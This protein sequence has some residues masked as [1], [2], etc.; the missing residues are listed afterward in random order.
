MAAVLLGV[1]ATLTAVALFNSSL[2][3]GES[4][5]AYTASTRELSD[6]NFYWS[7]GNQTYVADFALFLEFAKAANAGDD[8]LSEYVFDLMRPELQDAV[9][10][11]SSTG[12]EVLDP[13]DVEAGSPYVI[14]E[15]QI[16][17]ATEDRA[18]ALFDEAAEANRRGDRFS[19]ATVFFAL[20]LFFGGIATLFERRSV[21]VGLLAGAVVTL[22]VGSGVLITAF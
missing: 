15:E 21:T 8:E 6:A 2:R 17:A 18:Q 9:A 3:D 12:D 19:L 16:A 7:K 11:W 5:R 13:F 1:A 10:W 4:L 22:A 14:E 20:T